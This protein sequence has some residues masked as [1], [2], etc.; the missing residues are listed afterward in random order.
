MGIQWFGILGV[1]VRSPFGCSFNM[2]SKINRT[3]FLDPLFWNAVRLEFA[4]FLVL[5]LAQRFNSFHG[6][7]SE[8]DLSPREGGGL[9]RYFIIISYRE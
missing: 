8:P 7:G 9:G 5:M 2:H 3:H 4:F 6:Q 1:P